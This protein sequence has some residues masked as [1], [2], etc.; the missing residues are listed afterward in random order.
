[1]AVRWRYTL[2]PARLTQW[3][4][5]FLLAGAVGLLAAVLVVTSGVLNL[6]ASIPHPAG[7]ARFLHYTF[8]R[9]TAHHAADIVPP[10]NLGTPAEVAKGAVYYGMVCAHCHGGPNLGQNPVALSMR[11]QPQYLFKEV[12]GFTPSQL[13]WIV[14]HG[15]KYSAMPSFPVQ[16][17]DD[18]VW[19]VVSF[20]RA[21]PTMTTA[22]Y[23]QLAYGDGLA[24]SASTAVSPLGAR[25]VSRR[26]RLPHDDAWPPESSYMHPAIGFDDFSMT[27]DVVKTC[28][29]CHTTNGAGADG[30]AIPNIA[31]LGQGY[32]RTALNRFANGTRH[33]GYMQPVAMQLDETQ[34]A[35]LAAYYTAQPR[36]RSDSTAG[37][38]EQL[39]LGQRIAVVGI[40]A[41][42]IG[43]CSG[44]HDVTRAAAKA[45]PTIDGQHRLYLAGRLRQFRRAAP[46]IAGGNPMIAIA[47][48][49]EDRDIDAVAAFYASRAPGAPSPIMTVH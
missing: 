35:Q 5:P 16:D 32:F 45:F 25:F 1:M 40:P 17:R 14:K 39:A 10:A 6:S 20:L 24:A 26:Y 23:R 43:A 11:P 19:S 4:G 2:F 36:Q 47:H 48:K 27:G 13:F 46:P 31:I 42:G 38:P 8:R 12:G 7:W 49:L 30:G 29:R 21:M 15:V 28:A 9:S 22:R 34:M 33:S 41:H 44:C 3:A 37:T 18:E